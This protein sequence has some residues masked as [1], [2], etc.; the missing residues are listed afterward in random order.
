[1][2]APAA[3]RIRLVVT[4]MALLLESRVRRG[5]V[6]RGRRTPTTALPTRAVRVPERVVRRP[7]FARFAYQSR[8]HSRDMTGVIVDV[9]IAVVFSALGAVVARRSLR[10]RVPAGSGRVR[11]E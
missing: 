3:I 10:A 9:G 8:G 1:M 2:M 11:D 4:P 7:T 5:R 6:R